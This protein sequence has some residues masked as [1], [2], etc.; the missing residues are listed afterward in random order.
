MMLQE[1]RAE[2]Q[3]ATRAL[4]QHPLLRAAGPFADEFGL[5][6]RHREW[7]TDWL[8]RYPGWRLQIE[9]EFAR[10]RKT[11]GDITDSTRPAVEP[12][13]EIP[14]TRRRYALLCLALA[15]LERSDRQTALGRL[16]EDIE[17]LVLTDPQLQAANFRF[18]LLNHDHRRDL[19]HV[20]RFL[21]ERG[22]LVKI[23]GDELQYLNNEHGDALYNIHRPLL[24]A[25]VNVRRGP[26][27]IPDST[28]DGRI[29]KM[30]EEPLPD[31]ED[32]RNRRIRT[33]LVR[34]LLDDPVLYY[35]DLDPESLAYLHRQRGLL[36]S[37][38]EE[39][40]GLHPEVR[41]EGIAMTD[42]GGDLTDFAL[43]E[44]GTA[45]H[46]AL[47]LAEHLANYARHDRGSTIGMTSLVRRT[48][49]LI[50]EHRTH[51]NRDVSLPS[52]EIRMTHETLARLE[53]LRLVRR[54]EDGVVPMP[55]I[56]RYAIKDIQ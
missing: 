7:L 50:R 47:L 26:S 17:S 21:V 40:T 54:N 19:V 39:A 29:S 42:S 4:L 3:R 18:D 12:K 14:F 56:A 6:R 43:P 27:T 5:I 11:P 33:M 32:G 1:T 35:N 45:G 31:N 55:A 13:E 16:A 44:S 48:A 49:E 51:W 52:A 9:S 24:T 30:I 22:I 28:L 34:R 15:A 25:A 20:A 23:H 36:L 8:N 41:K 10:L 37:Q 53:A 46:L 38:I 2:R